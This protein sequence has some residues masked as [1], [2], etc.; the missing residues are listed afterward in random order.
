MKQFIRTESHTETIGLG[1]WDEPPENP[2]ITGRI[3]ENAVMDGL[4]N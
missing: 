2:W 4:L 3:R 1:A